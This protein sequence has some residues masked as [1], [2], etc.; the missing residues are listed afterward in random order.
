LGGKTMKAVG[1]IR[2][3]TA[4]QAR[5]GISLEA[6]ADKIR[7]YAD[8]HDL[9]VEIIADEGRSGKDWQRE[10]AKLLLERLENGDFEHLIVYKLDRLTRS[11]L[12]ALAI[13]KEMRERG[14]KF[15]S[16]CESLNTS[17]AAG[18]AYYGN[19]AVF[20]QFERDV[21]SERVK[22][23]FEYK[24][25]NGEWIG[26]APF[27]WKI[28]KKRLIPDSEAQKKVKKA[29]ILRESGEKWRD[30]ATIVNMDKMTIKR[31]VERVM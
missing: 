2:V 7:K 9:E 1:Y 12:D 30:I 24:R 18:R 15:H 31:A 10:G 8:L 6:Q 4:D 28:A 3:S 20:G 11:A 26:K 27:G 16:I 13:D 23:A 21:I 22:L 17:T 14:V 29:R 19:T 25:E 5:E